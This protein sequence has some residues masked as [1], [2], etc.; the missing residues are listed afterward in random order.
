MANALFFSGLAVCWLTLV[1]ALL[2]VFGRSNGPRARYLPGVGLVLTIALFTYYIVQR[3][4]ALGHFPAFCW[5]D[6]LVI[7]AWASVI[8]LLVTLFRRGR[9]VIMSGGMVPAVIAA[10][11]AAFL[12]CQTVQAESFFFRTEL[13][14]HVVVSFLG[15][16]ALWLAFLAGVCY[17]LLEHGL[18]SKRVDSYV[19]LLPPLDDL[20]RFFYRTSGVGFI[21][22]TLCI[23]GGVIFLKRLTGRWWVW[24]AKVVLTT[25]TWLTYAVILHQR[26]VAG[27][28]GRRVALLSLLGVLLILGTFVGVNLLAPG[29]GSSLLVK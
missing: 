2:G 5:H 16:A 8:I 26:A 6:L 7:F 24:D 25:V 28:R 11:W 13:G 19:K 14:L 20:D 12:P 4:Q 22:L 17:F 10:S 27:W 21:F 3:A 15:Y 29:H 1:L 23:I 9:P 18:K